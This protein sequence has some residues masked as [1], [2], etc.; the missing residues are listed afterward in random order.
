MQASNHP[1]LARL[2]RNQASEDGSPAGSFVAPVSKLKESPHDAGNRAIRFIPK[3]QT[4]RTLRAVHGFS[5]THCRHRHA[6]KNQ[7][8]GRR[9]MVRLRRDD[10]GKES[11]PC[12]KPDDC[13]SLAL[14]GLE[15]G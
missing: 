12:S 14:V 1:R 15:K 3:S 10:S 7:P 2:S 9:K 11:C 6:C 8:P 5:E 4:C 13:A